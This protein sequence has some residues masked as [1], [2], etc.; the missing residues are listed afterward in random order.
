MTAGLSVTLETTDR[1]INYLT[2]AI[3][4]DVHRDFVE[5]KTPE[6]NVQYPDPEMTRNAANERK[7]EALRAR[8]IEIA[9]GTLDSY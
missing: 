7:Y 5:G 9:H 8:I 2:D 6:E 3:R 4:E 1:I